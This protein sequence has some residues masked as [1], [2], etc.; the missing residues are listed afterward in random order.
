MEE[1]QSIQGDGTTW[2]EKA[3]TIIRREAIQF[4]R[5]RDPKGFTLTEACLLTSTRDKVSPQGWD[6]LSSRG[7]TPTSEASAY[8]AIC[9]LVDLECM[10]R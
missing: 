6:L 10:D 9:Q 7:L 2:W 8:S 4:E 5:S 3:Q 1:A